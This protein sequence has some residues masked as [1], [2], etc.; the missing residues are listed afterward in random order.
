[1]N[2]LLRGRRGARIAAITSG[3]AIPETANYN[4]VVE[5]EGHIVGT[6]D[7]DFAVESMAGDIFLLGTN[8]WRI[9]RVESGVVRVEDAH[10]SPPSVPFWNGEGPGRTVELSHEVAVLR[11]DIDSLDDA[12]AVAMLQ[13]QCALDR[14]GAEQAVAYIRGG[15]AILGVV[16]TDRR[17]SRNVFSTKAAGCS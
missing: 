17:S 15:K 6:L 11:H 14:A 16:P 3:G 7:E 1:M 4:V 12:A 9:R 2:G 5:P 13:A 10:G 8:S